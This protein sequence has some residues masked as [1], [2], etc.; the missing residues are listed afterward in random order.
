VG[1]A[2]LTGQTVGGLSVRAR[3]YNVAGKLLSSAH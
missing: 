3:V 1:I 2:N